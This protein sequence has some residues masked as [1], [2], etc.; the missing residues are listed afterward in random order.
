MSKKTKAN[1]VSSSTVADIV[2][3]TDRNVR[4]AWSVTTKDIKKK[5]LTKKIEEVTDF[6]NEGYAK[7]IAEAKKRVK[8]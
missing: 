4:N 7:L 5:P 2:G 6:L 1:K 3:C 8:L